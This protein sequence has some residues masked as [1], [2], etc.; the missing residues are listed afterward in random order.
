MT[1]LQTLWEI[2]DKVK[3]PKNNKNKNQQIIQK[4]I[5]FLMAVQP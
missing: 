5:W 4:Q 1:I 2:S 3:K